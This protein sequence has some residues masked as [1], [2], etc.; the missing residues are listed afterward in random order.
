MTILGSILTAED[1]RTQRVKNILHHLPK[2]RPVVYRRMVEAGLAHVYISNKS[3]PN[4]DDMG[5]L[6]GVAP[7]GWPPGITWDVIPGTY[8]PERHFLLLGGGEHGSRSLALHETGHA[9][10]FLLGYKDTP[11]LIEHH[12]RLYRKLNDY[13][14]QGGPGGDAGR[15]EFFAESIATLMIEGRMAAFKTYDHPY[16]E[17]LVDV[18]RS[19]KIVAAK[20]YQLS[21][22]S[23][24]ACLTGPLR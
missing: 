2:L 7:R 24:G 9:I 11:A 16:V 20:R 1:R 21:D 10:N 4:M 5:W 23:R 6:H 22:Y 13:E 19:P 3:V 14:R 8:D 15:D 18:L 17:W 12:K